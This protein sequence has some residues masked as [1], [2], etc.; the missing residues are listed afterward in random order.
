MAFT[1]IH[2][3]KLAQNS[4]IE[5]FIVETL[6]S[7]P[8]PS[9]AGR[10]WFNSATKQYKASVLDASG[11]VVVQVL[12][13]KEEFDAYVAN[14]A[15]QTKGEGS[16]LVGYAGKAGT[17]SQFSVVAGTTEASLDSVIDG[18]DANKQALANLGTGTLTNIQNEVDTIE[19][20]AGL[21][22]DGTYAA[23][24]SANYINTAASLSDADVKLDTQ[25]KANA[26]AILNEAATRASQDNLKV[27]KAGDVMT[28]DL[29]MSGKN[30]I[31]VGTPVNAT[32]AANKGYVDTAIQ[33]MDWKESVRAASTANV[34]IATGGL[35]TIDGVALSA[36]DRVLLM[37]QTKAA[38]NG[39]YVASSG[40]W[41]RSTD[42]DG[43]PSSEVSN[44]MATFVEEGTAVNGSNG[45]V[46]T[47]PNPIT[48]GTTDLSFS[49]F[50]GAGQIIAGA[51]ISKNGNEL[52][53]NFGAGIAQLPSDEIG[54]EVL[55]TG[56][57]FTTVDGSTSSTAAAALLAV[58]LDGTT[59]TSSA[60]GLK[61]STAYTAALNNTDTLQQNEID[62]IETGAGLGTDGSY[63][64]DTS[65]NYIGSASSLKNAD[66]LLDT[67]AKANADATALETVNRKAADTAIQS[68]L[69][70]VESGAG[71]GT[72]GSYTANASANYISSATSLKNADTLLDAQVKT[73]TDAIATETSART[74]DTTALRNAINA[75][76][77]TYQSSTAATSFTVKHNLGSAFV[78][79]AL[80]IEQSDG[81]FSNDIGQINLTDNN[82]LTVSLTA[83]RNIRIVVTSPTDV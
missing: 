2:G 13:N 74:S 4:Y 10:V 39:I 36:G 22:T 73:N 6:A 11:A 72:D 24:S 46:L 66:V 28:G 38:D 5:N 68:E 33:G 29:S 52:Y 30:I 64:A 41:S 61:I 34:D 19:T 9:V 16:A 69:D 40:A 26:D 49:Q 59:L 56:S 12:G 14:L 7:D 55:S 31:N 48:L 17:N 60:A 18:I 42:A 44:G 67:Q 82:S 70:T 62:A 8:T 47:T 65:T 54:V 50:S 45:Y 53:L 58:K 57:L 77:Y 51:G 79:V 23:D 21:N 43:N 27:S 71:L 35:L 20:G 76:S 15:S 75:N 3:L 81:T 83:A 1:E 32:D 80:W 63:T 25:A 78:T 37:G